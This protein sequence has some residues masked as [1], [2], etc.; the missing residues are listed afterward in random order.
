MQESGPHRKTRHDDVAEDIISYFRKECAVSSSDGIETT[1]G[2]LAEII[3]ATQAAVAPHLRRLLDYRILVLKKG[4]YMQGYR[5]PKSFALAEG[6]EDGDSWKEVYYNDRP[7]KKTSKPLLPSN[8]VETGIKAAIDKD[9]RGE[10]LQLH[11]RLHELQ[12]QLINTQRDRDKALE[13]VQ[14]QVARITELEQDIQSTSESARRNQEDVVA[15]EFQLKEARTKS[16][17]YDRT[18]AKNDGQVQPFARR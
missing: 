9:L 6:Y 5:G 15:L 7:D 11:R 16:N 12:E 18:I 14:S 8:L 3:K 10:V 1:S 17:L 13:T 2:K 4:V